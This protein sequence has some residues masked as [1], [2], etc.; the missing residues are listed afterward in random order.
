MASPDPDS[1]YRGVD[2]VHINVGQGDS[3]VHLL[4][5][6]TDVSKDPVILRATLIDGGKG[7]GF[8]KIKDSITMLMT[9]YQLPVGVT[10]LQF[11]SIVLTHWDLDHYKGV[12]D[13]LNDDLHEQIEEIKKTHP[14]TPA[15][16]AA[17]QCKYL[18]YSGA[19]RGTPLT[20]FYVPYW[21]GSSKG[22]YVP[23]SS[24]RKRK[25]PND[26]PK[27]LEKSGTLPDW[28]LDFKTYAHSDG[29]KAKP[30]P[31][32]GGFTFTGLC[33]LC[34]D[35]ARMIGVNFLDNVRLTTKGYQDVTDP[36][37]LVD[38]VTWQKGAPVGIFC[39]GCYDAVIGDKDPT[40]VVGC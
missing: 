10:N 24:G 31:E 8:Q 34:Y 6:T 20:T 15:E 14:P 13:L 22:F 21:D 25:Y 29:R 3:A 16:I 35:P 27:V 12:L 17:M 40:F 1:K 23:G 28:L 38:S 9:R 11:D 36:G 5:D 7:D 4:V 18:K 39:V 2:S 33:S 26:R 19:G 37:D 30:E 32:A